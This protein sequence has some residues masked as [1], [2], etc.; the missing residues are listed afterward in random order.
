MFLC[1]LGSDRHSRHCSVLREHGSPQ[2]AS[3]AVP[4]SSAS[5]SLYNEKWAFDSSREQQ[6]KGW[7]VEIK[8]WSPQPNLMPVMHTR[9]MNVFI[10]ILAAP[11]KII[12][13]PMSSWKAPQIRKENSISPPITPSLLKIVSSHLEKQP[14]LNPCAKPTSHSCSSAGWKR[15]RN[16]HIHSLGQAS[17]KLK[18]LVEGGFAREDSENWGLGGH[19]GVFMPNPRKI[20]SW[21]FT[22]LMHW[23]RQG[24]T[25]ELRIE[26]QEGINSWFIW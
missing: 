11:L 3:A 13:Y 6:P 24:H 9:K 16:L 5:M 26:Q 12:L 14:A 15:V 2:G 21:A 4:F 17:L 10:Q 25:L 1:L 7:S 18:L 22:A 23:G 19:L 20:I 8:S